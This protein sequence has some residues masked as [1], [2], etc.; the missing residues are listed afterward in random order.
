MSNEVRPHQQDLADPKKPFTSLK[1]HWVNVWFGKALTTP[2]K[3]Q[4]GCEKMWPQICPKYPMKAAPLDPIQRALEHFQ[5]PHASSCII[6]YTTYII[7]WVQHMASAFG[8]ATLFF[9]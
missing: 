3:D 8:G 9:L 2:S 7:T 5:A 4:E 1:L 6:T